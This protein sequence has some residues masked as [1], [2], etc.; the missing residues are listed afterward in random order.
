MMW[1]E[2][3]SPQTE[4]ISVSDNSS[5]SSICATRQPAQDVHQI[6]THRAFNAPIPQSESFKQVFQD[7]VYAIQRMVISSTQTG[8]IVSIHVPT[9]SKASIM[10]IMT[11]KNALFHVQTLSIMQTPQSESVYQL[12]LVM[13]PSL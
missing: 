13:P 3:D 6:P 11:Q 1:R 12:P 10:E 8:T 2:S 4:I 5:L 7:S 9:G